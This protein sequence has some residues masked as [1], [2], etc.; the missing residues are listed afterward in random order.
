MSVKYCERDIFHKITFLKQ[1]EPPVIVLWDTASINLI[2]EYYNLY[3]IFTQSLSFNVFSVHSIEENSSFEMNLFHI[4]IRYNK[5]KFVSSNNYRWDM[6]VVSNYLIFNLDTY[7]NIY[8]YILMFC[9]Y[10]VIG[11]HCV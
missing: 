2:I 10:V 8:I 1:P 11:L 7:I 5:G 3:I 6:I 4:K 9:S